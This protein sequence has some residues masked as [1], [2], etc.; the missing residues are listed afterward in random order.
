MT[1]IVV[2]NLMK[3][4]GS[5]VILDNVNLT[6]KKKEFVALVG[7]SGCG[8]TT[9]LRSISGLTNDSHSG[10]IICKRKIGYLFQQPAILPWKTVKENIEL[11]NTLHNES[12]D[13]SFW[14]NEMGLNNFLNHYPRELSGGLQQRTALAMIL[15]TDSDILL[16]DEPF[17][18][19]DEPTREKLNL[20][21]L[22]VWEKTRKTIIFVTHNIGEAVFLSD[23]VAILSKGKIEEIKIDLP[24]PRNFEMKYTKEF[25]K[26]VEEIKR[27]I[28]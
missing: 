16:L 28:A 26:Y 24:R 3:K 11:Y 15:L 5:N 22:A 21:I 14:I 25:G 6:V 1:E 13:S 2:S 4:F 23:K 8:K 10:S 20:L 18:A 7:T 17:S 27:K 19:L 12:R 9:L